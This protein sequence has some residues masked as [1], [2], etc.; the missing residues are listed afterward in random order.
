MHTDE[1]RFEVWL[2][3]FICVHLCLSVAFCFHVLSFIRH[4]DFDFRHSNVV[5]APAVRSR[6]DR[7]TCNKLKQRRSPFDLIDSL[8]EP[9]DHTAPRDVDSAG[10]EAQFAGHVANGSIVN[11]GL[12]E[13]M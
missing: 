8:A 4:S 7:T 11:G 3:E 2:V 13:G 1:H 5:P 9:G 10:C 6:S 12:P